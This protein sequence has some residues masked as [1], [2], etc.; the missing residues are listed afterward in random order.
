MSEVLD[1]E[2]DGEIDRT[3]GRDTTGRPPQWGLPVAIAVSGSLLLAV[4]VL[5]VFPA[6]T[7]SNASP[8]R[9]VNPVAQPPAVPAPVPP[10]STSTPVDARIAAAQAALAAWGEF[11]AHGDLERLKPWFAE[12]GPQ[13]RQLA[14][15]ADALTAIEGGSG[16]YMVMLRD[17][18]IVHASA[19]EVVVGGR[20]SWSRPP[21]TGQDYAWEVVLRPVGND[22]WQLWTVREG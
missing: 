21:E 3:G 2:V 1:I 20:V 18:A 17:A 14:G 16:S 9:A 13:Y 11:V 15:E 10:A 4:L 6:M 12:D 8:D 19:D 7:G 5:V 22:G